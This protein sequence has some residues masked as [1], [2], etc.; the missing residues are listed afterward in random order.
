M[1]IEAKVATSEKAGGK[2][3]CSSCSRTLVQFEY[4]L[5]QE[6]LTAISDDD[7]AALITSAHDHLR[8]K[9]NHVVQIVIY[10]R[11]AI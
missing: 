8:E 4:G 9:P 5:G 10:R 1:P 11:G 6:D 7:R 2:A 3:E